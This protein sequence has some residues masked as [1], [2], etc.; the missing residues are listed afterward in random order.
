M[1]SVPGPRGD[2]FLK[3]DVGRVFVRLTDLGGVILYD[4]KNPGGLPVDPVD[5][6]QPI[7]DPSFEAGLESNLTIYTSV[8]LGTPVS[9]RIEEANEPS[10]IWLQD[11]ARVV[12][13]GLIRS[14]KIAREKVEIVQ[15]KLGN[16][17]DITFEKPGTLTVLVNPADGY[18]GRP[19]TDRVVYL[20][21][22]L[23]GS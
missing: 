5:S 9:I 15:V 3:N 14:E 20:L 6:A 23:V 19:S 18:S 8:R 4:S 13:E 2:E 12:S 10:S 1:E 11:A 16:V 7:N 22:N 17:P 21:K